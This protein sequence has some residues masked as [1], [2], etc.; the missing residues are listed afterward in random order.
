MGSID[1]SSICKKKKKKE[2]SLSIGRKDTK[3]F[4]DSFQRFR[5]FGIKAGDSQ[6][7]PPLVNNFFKDVLNGENNSKDEKKI[8]VFKDSKK[9]GDSKDELNVEKNN[10]IGLNEIAEKEKEKNKKILAKM[11]IDGVNK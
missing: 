9:A 4:S 7:K 1:C 3:L 6:I 10:N 5:N 8:D 11:D 2:L